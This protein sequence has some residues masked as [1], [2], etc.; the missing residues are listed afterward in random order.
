M[1][2][3]TDGGSSVLFLA[4]LKSSILLFYLAQRQLEIAHHSSVGKSSKGHHP[5]TPMAR[6]PLISPPIATAVQIGAL[7]Q[8]PFS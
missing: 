8:A 3:P 4:E 1:G 7:P 5:L 6:T 2:A